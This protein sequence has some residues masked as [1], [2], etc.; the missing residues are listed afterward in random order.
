MSLKHRVKKLEA[1][2][3]TAH[4]CAAVPGDPVSFAR[5]LLAGAF[6]AGDLDPAHPHHTGWACR[7]SAFLIAIAPGHQAWLRAARERDPGAYPGNLLLPA[8]GEEIAAA[9]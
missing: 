6:G 2:V 1:V 5:G 8:S 4:P 7:V 3:P 9:L